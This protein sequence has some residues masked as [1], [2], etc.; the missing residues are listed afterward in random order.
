MKNKKLIPPVKKGDV[1]KLGAISI[2]SNGDVVFKKEGYIL[3]LK[4]PKKKSIRI[5]EQIKLKIV[6]L[7]PKLGY[8]ELYE[9]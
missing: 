6:K 5:G 9:I 8:V 3:F 1:V 7:F 2:G 4:N